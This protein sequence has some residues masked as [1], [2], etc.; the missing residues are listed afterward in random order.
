MQFLKEL[1]LGAK[2]CWGKKAPLLTMNQGD[3]KQR[4][5]DQHQ[6]KVPFKEHKELFSL[7]GKEADG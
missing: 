4:V 2:H 5:L 7:C 1:Q 3:S 6:Y